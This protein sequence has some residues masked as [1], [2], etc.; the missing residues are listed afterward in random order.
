MIDR[1]YAPEDAALKTNKISPEELAESLNAIAEGGGFITTA[2]GRA[3]L[4]AMVHPDERLTSDNLDGLNRIFELT[5][6]QRQ[7]YELVEQTLGFPEDGEDIEV[8]SMDPMKMQWYI[9]SERGKLPTKS[10]HRRML[11]NEYKLFTV[12]PYDLTHYPEGIE[13]RDYFTLASSTH[14]ARIRLQATFPGLA[15]TLTAYGR[16]GGKPKGMSE[17][18]DGLIQ[19]TEESHH[20]LVLFTIADSLLQRLVR[21]N[22]KAYQLALLEAAEDDWDDNAEQPRIPKY[23]DVPGDSVKKAHNSLWT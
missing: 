12:E 14:P 8:E 19:D 13:A 23:E 4:H 17:F 20:N 6:E 7:Y 5:P 1:D 22:D 10:E 15:Q 3:M 18:Y 16:S 9:H 11:N 21:P 2:E